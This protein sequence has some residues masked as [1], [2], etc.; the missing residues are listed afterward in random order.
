MGRCRTPGIIKMKSKTIL[1]ASVAL[2]AFVVVHASSVSASM[3][4]TS[5]QCK[6]AL[7][8]AKTARENEPDIGDKSGKV[9][10]QIMILAEQ[11]CAEKEFVFADQLLNVARGMVA[12]E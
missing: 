9:L 8:D 5:A 6:Q 11:R 12:S 10:D 7:E 3:I 1:F 4:T 2:M